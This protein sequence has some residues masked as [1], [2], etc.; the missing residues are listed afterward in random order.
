[1]A[2]CF[3]DKVASGIVKKYSSCSII[4]DGYRIYLYNQTTNNH[5]SRKSYITT[6][7][8]NKSR[9]SYTTATTN[10]NKSRKSYTATTTTN[11]NK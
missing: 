6:T 5:K 1:M 8:N 10:N 11:N 9:K 7:N 2:F 4:A 3:M